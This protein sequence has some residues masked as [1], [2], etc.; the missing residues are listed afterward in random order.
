MDI[1]SP[2]L[3]VRICNGGGGG[4]CMGTAPAGTGGLLGTW[5][6]LGG[7]GHEGR[8][9]LFPITNVRKIQLITE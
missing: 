9:G 6:L 1:A 5:I 4:A 3:F 8:G 7:G 2:C